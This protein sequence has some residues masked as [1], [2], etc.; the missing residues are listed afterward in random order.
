MIWVVFP[1]IKKYREA[2][3]S[4]KISEITRTGFE[5][6]VFK[7]IQIINFVKNEIRSKGIPYK[8]IF[9]KPNMDDSDISQISQ[10]DIVLWHPNVASSNIEFVKKFQHSIVLLESKTVLIQKQSVKNPI[11]ENMA[12]NHGFYIMYLDET[13]KEITNAEWSMVVNQDSYLITH[14][15]FRKLINKNL[16]E[17]D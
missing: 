12:I 13:D 5:T 11:T 4:H 10:D 1:A 6:I 17:N 9:G 8:I 7:Q 15:R 3:N 14:E 16:S 2:L